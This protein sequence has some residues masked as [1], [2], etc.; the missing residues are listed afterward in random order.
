MAGPAVPLCGLAFSRVVRLSRSRSPHPQIRRRV[1]VSGRGL[2]AVGSGVGG[3]EL[4][5]YLPCGRR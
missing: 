4:L 3:G 2:S 1:C 5:S